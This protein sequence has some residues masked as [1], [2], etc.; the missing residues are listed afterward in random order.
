MIRVERASCLL[1]VN[2]GAILQ[3][4]SRPVLV[5]N[6]G[7]TKWFPCQLNG[8]TTDATSRSS[9]HVRSHLDIKC[10][11]AITA[12]TPVPLGTA[13]SQSAKPAATTATECAYNSA[14]RGRR[15]SSAA[16]ATSLSVSRSLAATSSLSRE[17][18][19]Y[20]YVSILC[21][22]RITVLSSAYFRPSTRPNNSNLCRDWNHRI[23]V[24][25]CQDKIMP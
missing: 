14:Q 13:F 21:V 20:V 6:Q 1:L 8:K 9:L 16:R 17:V 11:H 2:V 5:L 4:L 3:C 15:L 18:S 19:V 12:C 22:V 24:I 10:S 7:H 25:S 23:H